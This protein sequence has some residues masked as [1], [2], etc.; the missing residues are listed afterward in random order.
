MKFKISQINTQ[1]VF[2]KQILRFNSGISSL[3]NDEKYLS[4]PTSYNKNESSSSTSGDYSST[5]LTIYGDPVGTWIEVKVNGISY[6]VG[7]GVRTKYC[8]FSNDGGATARTWANTTAGDELYWNG[9]IAGFEL[10]P[11]DSID[12]EYNILSAGAGGSLK[13]NGLIFIEKKTVLVD[14]TSVIFSGIDGYSDAIYH[15]KFRI[16]TSG[17]IN[18]ELR[19]NGLTTNLQTLFFDFSPLGTNISTDISSLI[20]GIASNNVCSGEGTFFAKQLSEG[21]NFNRSY[22]GKNILLSSSITGRLISGL[23]EDN[24][25]NITSL[26]INS[27]SADKIFAGSE[28]V[29]YKFAQ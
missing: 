18:F 20:I 10:D 25:T 11:A 27:V 19:P 17:S 1:Q 13:N 6:E 12:I 9:T 26:E 29:L 16:L 8:Y 3:I 4:T 24:I 21:T 28:L 22:Y 5:G 14:T 23:W 15:L 2:D 7:N